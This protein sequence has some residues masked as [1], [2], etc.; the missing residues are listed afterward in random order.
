MSK[1][2]SFFRHLRESINAH[3]YVSFDRIRQTTQADQLVDSVKTLKD[4]LTEAVAKGILHDAGK[5]WYSRNRNPVSL[6]DSTIR[7]LKKT[8]GK[9][10]PLL[11]HYLWSPLQ[12]NPWLHHQLGQAPTFVY[13]DADGIEDVGEFLREAGW[14]VAVNPGKKDPEPTRRGRSVVLRKVRRQIGDDEPT[15][16]TA[17]V[18][19]FMENNRLQLMDKAEFREMA[20]KLLTGHRINLARLIRLLGNR[21]R[22][23]TE[24]LGEKSTDYLGIS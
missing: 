8:L 12:F 6:D 13:V 7:E 11:P 14:N 21:K 23:I 18:D 19:L 20:R 24:I 4:Y 15:T 17:L 1:K 10:F 3:P 22:K 2:D 16:E 9:R 5:G